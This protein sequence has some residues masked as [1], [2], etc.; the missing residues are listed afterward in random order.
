MFFAEFSTS[1]IGSVA[2]EFMQ[3]FPPVRLVARIV[4]DAPRHCQFA[5]FTGPCFSLKFFNAIFF[6]VSGTFLFM[7][8]ALRSLTM[9]NLIMFSER[10]SGQRG[11]FTRLRTTL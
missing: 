7:D 8:S 9:S 1:V 6:S 10:S 3:P 11:L 2:V 4:W 5:Y